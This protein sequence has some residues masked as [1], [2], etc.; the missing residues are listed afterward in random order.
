MQA[1][2]SIAAGPTGHPLAMRDAI[3]FYFGFSIPITCCE[4]SDAAISMVA[5]PGGQIAVLDAEAQG[6]WW[7]GLEEPSAPKIFAK[8]PFV[9]GPGRPADFAA[10][11][12]GPRLEQV[13]TPDIQVFAVEGGD[14]FG[15]VV[16]DYG[17]VVAGR[18]GTEW[19]IELPVAAT[20][21]QLAAA[22]GQTLGPVSRIGDFFQ[23]IRVLTESA[24]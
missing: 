18:H 8:L 1:P 4:T 7:A 19:L 22:S 11:V 5:G 15:E 3:R 24:A 20:V 13:P 17:G 10:Y 2:F 12:V 14:G 16:A 9:E 21:D 23:P 6:R